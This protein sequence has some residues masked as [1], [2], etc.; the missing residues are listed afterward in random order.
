MQG[1]RTTVNPI[2]QAKGY[3]S[4]LY[5]LCVLL[6]FRFMNA[7]CRTDA[8]SELI[9]LNACGL[10]GRESRRTASVRCRGVGRERNA[11]AD[12]GQSEEL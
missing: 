5:L 2:E 8:N 9:W 12:P 3:L 7:L 10:F 4:H 6:D 1:R 11:D